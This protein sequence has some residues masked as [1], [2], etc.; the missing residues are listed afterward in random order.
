M[1]QDGWTARV[2]LL[3]ALPLAACAAVVPQQEYTAL[4]EDVRILRRDVAALSRSTEGSRAFAEERLAR[5]E[6]QLRERFQAIEAEGRGKIDQL[7]A[8]LKE[9]GQ[10]LSQSQG[11]LS[12]KIG[13]FASETRITQ[14]RLEETA[15]RMNELNQRIDALEVGVRRLT[16]LATQKP[17]AAP[18]QAPPGQRGPQTGGPAAGAPP[19][20]APG[21]P[22]QPIPLPPPAAAPAPEPSAPPAAVLGATPDE[23]YKAALN[24]YT[25]GNYDLAVN[26][27][28]TYMQLFPK[29]SL[30]SN[31]QYWLGESYY[32]QGKY[33]EA[34][35]EF[36]AV[37]K[38][39]PGSNKV[40]S[41]MLKQGYAYLE[42]RE[43]SR[44]TAVL[45]E[46]MKRFENSRE[47]RL[48]QERLRQVQ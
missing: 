36:E 17:A 37:I 22:A 45:R 6:A 24:D 3:L 20:A 25:K 47:A 29:T 12:A 7:L 5:V 19:G 39:H 8:S 34:I 23:V 21:L 33:P 2:P 38:N 32:S 16:E 27:F 13:E 4:Q 9:E 26:G 40:P 41:A 48:A 28:K 44:G 46:L 10:R 18:A 43:T 31:A 30:V 1:Q 42:L 11:D 14:G 15:H 35:R